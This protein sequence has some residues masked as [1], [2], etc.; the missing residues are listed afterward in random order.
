MSDPRI[1]TVADV[2]REHGHNATGSG[3]DTD[4]LATAI[5][6]ALDAKHAE[7]EAEPEVPSG[8]VVDDPTAA[9]AGN[10]E[11]PGGTGIDGGAGDPAR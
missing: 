5:V 4:Q 1:Q 3:A 11:T 7:P 8:D 2:L 9:G 6:N 10:P